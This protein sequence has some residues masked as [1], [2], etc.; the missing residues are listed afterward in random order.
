MTGENKLHRKSKNVL[1]WNIDC[2]A[3]SLVKC[4]PKPPIF[5]VHDYIHDDAIKWNPFPR[6]WTFVRGIHRSPVNSPHKGQWRGALM[7]SLICAWINR[8]VNNHE[9]GDLRRHRNHYDVIVIDG[10]VQDCST[11]IASPLW[12][13]QYCTKTS[14]LPQFK[15]TLEVVDIHTSPFYISVMPMI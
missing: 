2:A 14:I 1:L 6:Y 3:K 13:Q 11:S 4:V 12:I 5:G 8:W 15:Y 10:L 9:A 7:F